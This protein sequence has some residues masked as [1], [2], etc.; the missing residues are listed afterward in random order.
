MKLETNCKTF[1]LLLEKITHSI[2]GICRPDCNHLCTHLCLISSNN[3]IM[4]SFLIFRKWNIF[5]MITTALI[6]PRLGWEVIYFIATGFFLPSADSPLGLGQYAYPPIW[7]YHN[8]LI[9]NALFKLLLSF[10]AFFFWMDMM[11]LF[12]FSVSVC[13]S[14]C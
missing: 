2:S 11:F 1:R 3:R 14:V 5:D 4:L 10:N 13:E 6:G 9:W 12:F 8:T 7:Y